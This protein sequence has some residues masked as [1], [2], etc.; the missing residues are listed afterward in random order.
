MTSGMMEMLAA[1]DAG[2]G[3]SRKPGQMA[4][5]GGKL[6]Y[7]H[8]FSD[9]SAMADQAIS[10][11]IAHTYL[12][13]YPGVVKAARE[14]WDKHE[15]EAMDVAAEAVRMV[16]TIIPQFLPHH[17]VTG[18]DIDMGRYM[19]GEPENMVE[20]PLQMVSTV[21]S[22]VTLC[23]DVQTTGSVS[24]R[25]SVRRGLTVAGL[26]MALNRL[27]HQTDLWL[28]DEYYTETRP[29]ERVIIRTHVKSPNDFID[30]KRIM[31][32]FAHPGVQRGLGF[33]V[34][35]STKGKDGTYGAA[36]AAGMMGVVTHT[37]RNLPEGTIYLPPLYR[38]TD[39]PNA[40]E[41]LRRY[42]GQ[43]GLTTMEDD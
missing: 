30:P 43:I 41:E 5:E 14:G 22:V 10:N 19:S 40:A 12:D 13:R 42:L 8:H 20:Y 34:A 24:D 38:E 9:L 25:C 23:A 7:E 31:F 27:G 6:V 39:A 37:T 35:S 26:A 21:G 2:K 36:L 29:D 18:A 3:L 11:P 32:A 15:A 17:D 4:G 16:E 1:L 28:S 33:A